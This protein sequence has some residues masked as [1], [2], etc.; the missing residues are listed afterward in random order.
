[1]ACME[2]CQR[3][4]DAQSPRPYSPVQD[5]GFAS[6][7]TGGTPTSALAPPV[8]SVPSSAAALSPAAAGGAAAS[9]A[10][11]PSAPPSAA[12]PPSMPSTV[13]DAGPAGSP[14]PSFIGSAASPDASTVASPPPSFIGV[15]AAAPLVASDGDAAPRGTKTGASALKVVVSALD[16]WPAFAACC[17]RR[18]FICARTSSSVGGSPPSF[19]EARL[20]EGCVSRCPGAPIPGGCP[21]MLGIPGIPGIIPGYAPAAFGKRSPT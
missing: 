21:N 4:V 7:A 9:S 12:S 14:P 3:S 18:A 8:A 16:A 5:S 15:P 20:A 17:K 19:L 11:A 2:P 6:S 1:M 10:A 13:T